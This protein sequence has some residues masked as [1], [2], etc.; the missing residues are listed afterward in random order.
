MRVVFGAA[1]KP[2]AQRDSINSA[3]RRVNELRP[4]VEN[5]LD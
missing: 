5:G 3:R 4:A 1:Q 2:A